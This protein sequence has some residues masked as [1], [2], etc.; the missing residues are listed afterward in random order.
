MNVL[1]EA[2]A[3]SRELSLP[4]DGLLTGVAPDFVADL[5]WNGTFIEYN[6]QVI[7]PATQ[8]VDF[9]L[10][11]IAGEAHLSRINENYSRARVGT[12]TAGQ[13]FG[14]TNLFVRAPSREEL[15]AAGEVI[16]WT[17]ATDT[18]RDLLLTRPGAVQLLYNI[19]VVL[20]QKLL[21][22][23]EGTAAVSTAAS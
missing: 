6:Q 20:A 16:V 22:K 7:A 21:L 4:A 13:W 3:Q 11:V 10:C 23:H 18:L 2:Q 14:E 17:I 9:I 12:L 8:P 15:F 19:G 1:T 5:Q